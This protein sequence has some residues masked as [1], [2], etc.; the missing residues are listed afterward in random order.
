MPVQPPIN[1]PVNSGGISTIVAGANL[2]GGTITNSGTISLETI[3]A[4]NLFGNSATIAGTMEPIAIGSNLTLVSNGTLNATGGLGTITPSSL[5]GN[6]GTVSGTV[7]AIAVGANLTLTT[8]G[9]LNASGGGGGGGIATI[10]S[11]GISLSSSPAIIDAVEYSPPALTTWLNQNSATATAF[12]NGPLVLQTTQGGTTNNLSARY[13]AFSGAFNLIAR[14]TLNLVFGANGLPAGG[15]VITDGTKAAGF[16][17][18]FAAAPPTSSP[19]IVLYLYTNP[20]TV[21]SAP[22]ALNYNYPGRVWLGIDFDGTSTWKFLVSYDGF[23]WNQVYSTTSIGFIPTGVGIGLEC[24]RNPTGNTMC[25][26]CDYWS[27]V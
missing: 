20:T 4:S 17:G 19:L 6:F 27:G 12:S 25:V 22:L 15:L 14:M 11:S 3:I 21:S 23:S 1:P 10:I 2:N 18:Q 26:G 24:A 7:G 9:I 8:D 13:K 5:V 16:F